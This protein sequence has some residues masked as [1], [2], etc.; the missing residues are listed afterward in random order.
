M[1]NPLEL[2]AK[3]KVRYIDAARKHGFITRDFSI[4]PNENPDGPHLART[5]M[6]ADPEFDPVVQVEDPEFDR[7]IREAEEAER[8]VKVE[9]AR[10]NMESLRD[11]LKDPKKGLWSD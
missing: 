2:L 6:F 9:E 7:I 1:S 5:M 11:N 8:A 10:K 4:V 3:L